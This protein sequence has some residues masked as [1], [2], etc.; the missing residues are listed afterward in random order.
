MAKRNYSN[1]L[2]EIDFTRG[3]A[4]LMMIVFHFVW[5]LAAFGFY[6]DTRS[7]ISSPWQIFAR[8]TGSIFIFVMGLSL[9]LS[10]R[11]TMKTTGRSNLLIKFIK[12]GF[13][14]FGVG[15]VITLVMH[16]TGTGCVVFGILH[17][18]GISIIL[19]YPL[20]KAPRFA[21]LAIAPFVLALGFYISGFW[22]DTFWFVPLGFKMK[23]VGM[24]DYYPIFP[25]FGF[26][27][28]GI[29]A[30]DIFYKDG[31]RK[32]SLP[33]IGESLIVRKIRFLGRHSLV[34]YLVHQPLLYGGLRLFVYL[35]Y[36]V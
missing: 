23:G 8:T 33:E 3:V 31:I 28:L 15:M 5:N 24:S 14:I 26:A 21:V 1:R 32:F 2:W 19:S 27:L 9:T 35:K 11:Q 17:L 18:I 29:F 34:I 16:F 10:Y 36:G 6:M 20:L 22:I 7:L 25:W 12:R 30:G 4:V 13:Q